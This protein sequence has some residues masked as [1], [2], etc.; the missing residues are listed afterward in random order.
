MSRFSVF[1]AFWNVE[2]IDYLTDEYVEW[3]ISHKGSDWVLR[4]AKGTPFNLSVPKL[5]RWLISPHNRQMLPAALVHDELLKMGADIA[6]ASAEFRRAL[7]ARG[8]NGLVAW[9]LFFATFVYLQ[10][11]RV[12]NGC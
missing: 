8:V 6:F 4:I 5:L 10:S 3:D 1:D 11:K 2:G 9:A 7:R 12:L